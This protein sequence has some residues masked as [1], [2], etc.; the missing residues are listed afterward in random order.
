MPDRRLALE[1]AVD[2]ADH[3]GA[4]LCRAVHV[5]F[6]SRREVSGLELASCVRR[7]EG[8]SREDDGV[9]DR[10]AIMAWARAPAT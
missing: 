2:D 3:L 7:A 8:W 6:C 4:L 9:H 10:A 1:I 5:A